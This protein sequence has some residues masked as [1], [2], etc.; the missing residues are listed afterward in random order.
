M[1]TNK[2]DVAS[3]SST[4]ATTAPRTQDSPVRLVI[5][6]GLLAVAVG[7][8]AYDHFVAKPACQ[9]ADEKIQTFVDEQNKLGVKVGKLVTPDDIHK[10]L[11][12]QPTDVVDDDKDSYTI[13]YYRW[14]GHV[15]V[16]NK[17]RHFIAVVYT[18]TKPRHFSSH[19]REEPQAEALPIP[20]KAE[21]SDNATPP[22]PLSESEL[23]AGAAETVKSQEG[24][25]KGDADKSN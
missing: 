7:A 12:T 2:V 18:G 15:P 13:E 19:H 22:A 17:R 14:W 3:P 8:L 4:T 20:E 10:L 21:P 23:A 6:L 5:L 9:A 24:A 1:T 16:I 11:N 25:A